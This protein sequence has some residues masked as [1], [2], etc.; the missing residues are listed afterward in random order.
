MEYTCITPLDPAIFQKSSQEGQP[1]LISKSMPEKN[2]CR[3]S[4]LPKLP[5][6]FKNTLWEIRLGK[7]DVFMATLRSRVTCKIPRSTQRSVQGI[8]R[9]PIR[10]AKF[11]F[12]KTNLVDKHFNDFA[13]IPWEDTPN[14]PKTQQRKKFLHKPLVKFLGYLSRGMWVRS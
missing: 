13:H 11:F 9:S 14:F 1:I 8:R 10:C 7:H 12:P 3:R 5:I 6:F 4:P 2:L